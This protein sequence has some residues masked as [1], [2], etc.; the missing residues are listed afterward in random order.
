M[1]NDS[2]KNIVGQYSNRIGKQFVIGVF[3]LY[4]KCDCV[5][6]YWMKMI[7][8]ET[9]FCWDYFMNEYDHYELNETLI[10]FKS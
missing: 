8:L 6:A 4:N 5:K 2:N 1:E 9:E 7:C 10:Y 3:G